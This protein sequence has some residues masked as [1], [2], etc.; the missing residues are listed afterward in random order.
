MLRVSG[1]SSMSCR[2]CLESELRPAAQSALLSALALYR[3][4]GSVGLSAIRPSG[5]VMTMILIGL[6]SG[7][8]SFSRSGPFAKADDRDLTGS[9]TSQVRAM[10]TDSDLAFAR[11]AASDV[12]SK[13]DN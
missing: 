10:P 4:W 11:N 13:G 9:I 1:V 2:S 3:T 5:L 6:G 8:C 12:L 7:G